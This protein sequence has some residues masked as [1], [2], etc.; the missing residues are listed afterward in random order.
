MKHLSER[1]MLSERDSPLTQFAYLELFYRLDPRFTS[2]A[3][4]PIVNCEESVMEH[5]KSYIQ[6]SNIS[7]DCQ[8]KFIVMF[9]NNRHRLL[10][11]R[12]IG[13]GL[14]HATL[15][16]LKYIV[17]LA[18]DSG[19]LHIIAIHNHP[20]CFL[21]PSKEDFKITKAIQEALRWFD[22]TLVDHIIVSSDLQSSHSMANKGQLGSIPEI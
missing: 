21:E 8:E 22:I 1:G 4:L 19:A 12:T 2:I 11:I 18:L 7:L 6:S 10:A 3:Q 9:L 17:K 14:S 5:L 16:D 13:I 20:S 15:V